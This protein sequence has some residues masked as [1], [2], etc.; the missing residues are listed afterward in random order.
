MDKKTIIV[1]GAGII[2]SILLAFISI[3]LA[4][5]ALIIKIVIGMSL[6][7]MQDTLFL[8]NVVVTLKDDARG[9][10]LTNTGNSPAVKIHVS[11]VPMNTEYDLAALGIDE[12]HEYVLESMI[13]EV[14]VVVR[15]ENENGQPFSHSEKL[16][17][18]GTEFEPLKP[19]IPLFKWK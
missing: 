10:V 1:L 8:P 17:A 13:Q 7:I 6:M 2:L 4:G 11:L 3:Y 18:Y 14:K 5:I 15:F 19:I 12:S 16:S 9:I